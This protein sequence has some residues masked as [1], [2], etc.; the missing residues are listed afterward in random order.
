MNASDDGRPPKSGWA[1]LVPEILVQDLA[2]SC[3]FWLNLLGFEI[4]YQRPEENFVYLERGEGAQI[5]L[6]QRSGKWETAPMTTPYGRG[7]MFQ[8][9]VDDLDAIMERLSA[10]DWPL[11]AGPRDTWRRWGDREGGSREILVQ[12]PDGY[13]IMI[14]QDLGQRPLT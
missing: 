5:M 7:A 11:Y 2:V 3:S 6:S 12:D 14:A 1:R 9:A 10:A 13:L 4:A 8:V